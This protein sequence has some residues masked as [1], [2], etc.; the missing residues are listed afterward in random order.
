MQLLHKMHSVNCNAWVP[1]HR[2]SCLCGGIW[3]PVHSL[4][5]ASSVGGGKTI[6]DVSNKKWTVWQETSFLVKLFFVLLYTLPMQQSYD[7]GYNTNYAP[8]KQT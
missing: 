6:C 2:Q 3:N 5:F 8:M 4:N 1:W 7:K